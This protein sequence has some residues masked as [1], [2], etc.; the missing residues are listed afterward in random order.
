[1][2]HYL[3]SKSRYPN[4]ERTDFIDWAK[5]IKIPEGEKVRID[6]LDRAFKAANYTEEKIDGNPNPEVALCRYEYLEI[7]LRMSKV[8]Y[9]DT[10]L[11]KT[12][13][14]AL[15]MF[16]QQSFKNDA[17]EDWTKFRKK[18]LWKISVNDLF[19]ANIPGLRK[20]YESYF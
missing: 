11:T 14:E 13:S 17:S 3:L 19:V 12:F 15:K 4:I 18:L 1:M 20:L 7:V 8:K 9:I 10:G 6:T 2:Y 5:Q 16:M